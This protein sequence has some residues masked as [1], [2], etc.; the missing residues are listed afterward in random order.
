MEFLGFKYFPEV[1]SDKRPVGE[2]LRSV[3]V[4]GAL[5]LAAEPID[6]S[7]GDLWCYPLI[8]FAGAG[9]GIAQFDAKELHGVV[10]GNLFVRWE[11]KICGMGGPR[12]SQG[13]CLTV[14]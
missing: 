9:R 6:A 4:D 7:I 13:V 5:D 12:D 11:P 10:E 8:F 2:Q 3:L 1:T 14:P